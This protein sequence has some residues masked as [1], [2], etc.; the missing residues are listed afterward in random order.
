MKEVDA[1]D[2]PACV[3]PPYPVSAGEVEL[4]S[5]VSA[6]RPSASVMVRVAWP[7]VTALVAVESPVYVVDVDHL[8]TP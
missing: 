3:S 6:V 8:R 5:R 7:P 2:A 4:Y 1:Y